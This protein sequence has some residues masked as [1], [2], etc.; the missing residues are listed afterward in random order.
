MNILERYTRQIPIFGKEGQMKLK[1]SKVII[2]GV[3]GLGSVVSTY[4]TLAGVGE[5]TIIDYDTIEL[6]NLNRQ[7]LHTN[8]DINKKKVLSGYEKLSALNPSIK[9]DIIDQKISND[10]IDSLI[11]KDIILVEALDNIE[12]RKI[13]FKYAHENKI[14][15]FHAGVS[16]FIGQVSTF[17]H[18]END[19]CLFCIIPNN[20]NKLK[21]P[22]LGSTV[23]V[24]G[25][26]QCNEVIKYITNKGSLLL[27][28]MLIWNGL[29]NTIDYIAFSK[30]ENCPIC[31]K[32]N[33]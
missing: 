25:S 2:V 29:E 4:L 3:G 31:G 27:K 23:G 30:N 13:L 10:N 26:I 9:I 18:N 16:G 5:I 1:H 14:P 20:E 22:V 8:N 21:P 24:I 17:L 19:P 15:Y 33:K 28:K 12:S 32:K 7:F 6:S 11:K